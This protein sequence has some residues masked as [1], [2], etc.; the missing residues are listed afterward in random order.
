MFMALPAYA[1]GQLRIVLE[2]SGGVE[3]NKIKV[4]GP[5]NLFLAETPGPKDWS[6]MGAVPKDWK[7]I[8]KIKTKQPVMV[9]VA[10]LNIEGFSTLLHHTV[11][12]PKQHTL[13]FVPL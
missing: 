4:D 7:P 1:G 2:S 8:T 12:A 9:T 13:Y 10:Y 11:S 3:S 6:P 5:G